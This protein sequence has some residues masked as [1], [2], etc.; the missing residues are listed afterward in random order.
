MK[1]LGIALIVSSV[2]VLFLHYAGE[3]FSADICL[4]AGQVYDYATSQC[5]ADVDNLPNIPYA[6]RFSRFIAGSLLAMLSG[7][8]CVVIGKRKKP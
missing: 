6:K 4:D 8:A 5:H 2:A 1:V 7:I 3:F